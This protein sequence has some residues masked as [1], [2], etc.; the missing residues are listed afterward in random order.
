MSICVQVYIYIYIYIYSLIKKVWDFIWVP[1][2]NPTIL[3]IR[4]LHFLSI[5]LSTYISIHASN[6]KYIYIHVCMCIY[7]YTYIYINVD[8]RIYVCTCICFESV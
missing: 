5:N 1:Y 4:S 3:R 2:L 6:Y 8:T 7:I